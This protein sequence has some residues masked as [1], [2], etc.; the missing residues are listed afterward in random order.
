MSTFKSFLLGFKAHTKL[1][2]NEKSI[3]VCD[4]QDHIREFKTRERLVLHLG[5]CTCKETIC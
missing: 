2:E 3:I 4:G 5:K 1:S